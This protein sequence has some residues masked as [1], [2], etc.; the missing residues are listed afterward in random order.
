[1]RSCLALL[2][3]SC[4]LLLG[5]GSSDDGPNGSVQAVAG[6]GSV[7]AVAPLPDP[8]GR[9]VLVVEGVRGGNAGTRTKI[10]LATLRRLPQATLTVNDPF[11][12]Q[13]VTY[14]GVTMKDLLAAA[15]VPRTAGNL[16]VH[17]L[18]DYHVDLPAQD[19]RE[20]TILAWTAGGRPIPVAQGGPVRMIFADSHELGRNRDNWIWSI[21]WM[22]A[23]R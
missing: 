8:K 7:R 12:R 10:D 1:M 5:C 21:D 17:A 13:S 9:P 19:L 2:C 23:G 4:L 16:L 18:D 14:G 15:G 20:D 11:K 6:S 22:R 3:L